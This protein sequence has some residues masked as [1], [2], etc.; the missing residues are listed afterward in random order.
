[1]WY[2]SSLRFGKKKILFVVVALLISSYLYTNTLS[3]G[4]TSFIQL[5]LLISV[6]ISAYMGGGIVIPSMLVE[7][8]D[9]GSWKNGVERSA[10]YFSIKVFF[11]KAA[12][13]LGAGTG[14]AIAGGFGFIVTD[15][16][17]TPEAINGLKIAMVWMPTLL[18]TLSLIFVA[19]TPINERRHRII[20]R[21]LDARLKRS[22]RSVTD[23]AI[24]GHQ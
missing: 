18:G 3:P 12:G 2:R 9:Y 14:L 21:H 13:A 5:L 24:P 19:L 1:L 16:D 6:H 4:Q 11:E 10:T 20:K 22:L 15:S 7:I 17:F 8:V 23:K